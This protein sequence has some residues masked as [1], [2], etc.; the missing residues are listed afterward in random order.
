[1]DKKIIKDNN[2][3]RLNRLAGSIQN[4]KTLELELDTPMDIMALS[5]GKI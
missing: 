3:E 4:R 5:S 1:M 2:L